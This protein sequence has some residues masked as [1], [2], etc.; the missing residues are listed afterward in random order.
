[1]DFYREGG[2]EKH[3][4]DIASVLKIQGARI[5][6]GYIDQWATTLGLQDIWQAV[7]QRLREP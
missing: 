6:R 3:L 2:S 1:M 5:D 4:R 7:Q